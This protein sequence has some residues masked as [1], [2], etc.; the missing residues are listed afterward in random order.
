MHDKARFFAY[1]TWAIMISLAIILFTN[2]FLNL[3]AEPGWKGLGILLI[4]GF[5]YMNL[6]YTVVKRYIRKVSAPTQ[7]HYLLGVFIFIP[8]SCWIIISRT[9]ITT[10]QILLVAVLALAC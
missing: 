10:D 8:P 6:T 1:S 2:R 4:F 7:L 9:G 5:V 3:I